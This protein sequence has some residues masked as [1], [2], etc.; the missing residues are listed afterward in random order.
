[1]ISPVPA[2]KPPHVC[3]V[4]D[5]ARFSILFPGWDRFSRA[6][7]GHFPEAAKIALDYARLKQPRS[8]SATFPS[9]S[10][11]AQCLAETAQYRRSGP[12]TPF[13]PRGVIAIHT[14]RHAAMKSQA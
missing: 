2:L 5:D 7:P 4:D 10:V 9:G 8:F 3:G 6:L 12:L 13:R 1:M 11:L 14:N